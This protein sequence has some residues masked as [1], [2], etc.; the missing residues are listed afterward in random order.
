[1]RETIMRDIPL[2]DL[3]QD[4]PVPFAVFTLIYDTAATVVNTRY[5]YVN[6]AY[7]RMA[8]FRRE[9]LIGRNF[10][11][12]YPEGVSW[13]PYCQ[14]AREKKLPVHACVYSKEIGRWLDFTV[15][16]ATTENA[17]AFIFTD[18]DESVRKTR[19]VTKTDS[20]IL[21]IS[22]LLNNEEDF[23][24]GMN[25]AL[26][27][28][29]RYIHP[30]RLY[31]LE[32]DG[33]TASNTFEWCAP[34]VEP[35]MDTLQ[36][37]DYDGY[38]SGWEKYLEKSDSV[39]IADIEELRADDPIDYENLRRQGIRC[40]A[41]APFYNRG[42]LIGYLGAD[43]YE[44]SDLIN[45]QLVLNSISYFIGAKIVNHRLMEDLNRLSHMDTLTN[46][47]NRNAMIARMNALAEQNIPTGLVYA[48]VNG[49]KIINDE[50]GHEAG[51]Q[52]LQS[53]ADLLGENFGRRHVYRAG[54]DEFVVI[55]PGIREEVFTE[56]K[57]K[58][59]AGYCRTMPHLLSIGCFWCPDSSKIE[60]ALRIA[61]HHM[62]EEK[63]Q[64][65]EQQEFD[66]RNPD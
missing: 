64:Y 45:T 17:V 39:V 49:L 13:M 18:V 11:D 30:D 1:M 29:S 25:H 9:N 43:N 27:D 4:I 56:K 19:R 31:V 55:L 46:V 51:D 60:E 63:K 66:R 10:L 47:F 7:C 41:A 16:P 44:K 33:I 5:L 22:K 8:G 58:L 12:I 20:I 23:E 37:L 6:E 32:T 40:L 34:G 50:Q 57:E 65:Y 54:G 59:A 38:L 3:D 21:R 15:G 35:E 36:N 14:E 62:Y 2:L 26:E 42:K 61:D 53:A 52:A 28:L 24:A 48:D